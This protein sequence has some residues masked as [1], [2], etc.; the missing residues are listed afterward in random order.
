M[1]G[2]TGVKGGEVVILSRDT[3]GSSG[4]GVEDFS[5]DSL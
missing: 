1:L 3:R 4:V 5:I 2:K